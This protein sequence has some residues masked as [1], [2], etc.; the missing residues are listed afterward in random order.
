M[1]VP[2]VG[3]ISAKRPSPREP[4]KIH[5]IADFDV[6]HALDEVAH[7]FKEA[8]KAQR[9][10]KS[11]DIATKF[12][13]GYTQYKVPSNQELDAWL[14]ET[15]DVADTGTPVHEALRNTYLR[16]NW[17]PSLH[18]VPQYI[19]GERCR[20]SVVLL[21]SHWR[22]EAQGAFKILNQLF[23]Y[24][25]DLL[26]ATSTQEAL[27]KHTSGS[28]ARLLVPTIEEILMPNKQSP[29]ESK[30]R[31]EKHFSKYRSHL[32]TIEFP[33]KGSLSAPP[34]DMKRSQRIYTA[35]STSRLVRACK[36]KGISTTAAIH[37]A[38]LGA[39]WQ[40]A[41][42]DNKDRSYASMMPAQVRTRLPVSS[43]YREQ[44]CWS[45]ALML[46]ITAPV[47]QDFLTRAQLLREQYKLADD[48]TWLCEDA[49]ELIRQTQ[50]PSGETPAGPAAIPWF[51]SIGLLDGPAFV[52]DHGDLKVERVAVWADNFGP[53]IVLGQ[54]S[55]RGRLNLHIH[56]NVSYQTDIHIKDCLDKL[57]E[58]L[59]MEL[60]A[61]MVVEE[62][63][64][65]D[66]VY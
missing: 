66:Q 22:T 24:A 43:P 52:P 34:S 64:G 35:S 15:F 55:F 40:L 29:P 36:A 30:A 14:N 26:A 58:I 63:R 50:N 4:V 31:I 38:Y 46:Y 2:M 37:S 28:E 13:D 65:H 33:A 6:P 51:T 17:L 45:A 27:M 23:D 56:W 42:A 49:R 57:E 11:P 47:N 62:T 3:F 32:P 41:P 21:I 19:Q 18:V 5:C 12:A 1:E 53:G 16:F 59:S 10:L 39:V 44:G 61:E 7:A 20:G 8:W 48:P 25:S 54:W 60:G 9:L